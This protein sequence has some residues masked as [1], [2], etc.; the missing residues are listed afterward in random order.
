M[1][2]PRTNAILSDY[3]VTMENLVFA[4]NKF[5]LQ[6]GNPVTKFKCARDVYKKLD[7][8]FT[9]KEAEEAAQ[10]VEKPDL[11]EYLGTIY[12]VD[13][14]VDEDMKDGEWKFE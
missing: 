1:Q 13:I 9:K 3:P 14:I 12:G 2:S 10:G 7:D 4:M 11:P 5:K 8:Y 6:Y